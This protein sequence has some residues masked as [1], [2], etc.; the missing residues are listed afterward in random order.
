MSGDGRSVTFRPLP[1]GMALAL[2]H[3]TAAG[4]A[5]MRLEPAPRD[6]PE[7]FFERLFF[8]PRGPNGGSSV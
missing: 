2:A 4:L 8:R 3:A 7:P 5:K 6:H 1:D